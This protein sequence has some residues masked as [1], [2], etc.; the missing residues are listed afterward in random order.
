MVFG[1]PG[2]AACGYVE[3]A[4]AMN[5]SESYSL[6]FLQTGPPMIFTAPTL[7]A[8]VEAGVS[9]FDLER[10]QLA[11]SQSLVFLL[12]FGGEQTRKRF[13]LP[14]E[15]LLD[16]VYAEAMIRIQSYLHSW[17]LTTAM[18]EINE[19]LKTH[20]TYGT[21]NEI[22]S[23]YENVGLYDQAIEMR[24]KMRQL[25][26]QDDLLR[27]TDLLRLAS[28]HRVNA[29]EDKALA[30]LGEIETAMQGYVQARDSQAFGRTA[31]VRLAAAGQ[32]AACKQFG[33]AASLIQLDINA[34][35][36]Q[37]RRLTDPLMQVCIGIYSALRAEEEKG[38]NLSP[39]DATLRDNIAA[40][41]ERAFASGF[42]QE[43]DDFN[44][45]LGRYQLLG[46]FAVAREGKAASQERLLAAGPYPEKTREHW[47]RGAGITDEDWTWFRVCPP[48]YWAM[49]SALMDPEKPEIYQPE[50]ALALLKAMRQ[51]YQ[52]V[53]ERG[54]GSLAIMDGL[55]LSAAMRQAFLEKDL[56]AFE[57]LLGKIKAKNYSDYFGEAADEFGRSIHHVAARDFAA[58]FDRLQRSMPGKQYFFRAAYVAIRSKRYEQA[59]AIAESAAKAFPDDHAMAQEA[60]ALPKLIEKLRRRD[61]A[62]EQRKQAKT[63]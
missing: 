6:I 60:R 62:V 32:L 35:L 31:T 14:A 25:A 16:A 54:L 51:G 61:Q 38:V 12:R 15:V 5:G 30:C 20:P 55:M 13:G 47:K 41:L 19:L 22:F 59:L 34:A 58:W 23:I 49:A 43:S 9:A 40:L 53:A 10:G 21:Y 27:L 37:Q 11:N 63:P 50:Q 46:A 4:K 1:F 52:A 3:R 57:R 48:L 44:R 33:R 7:A 36:A 29:E 39:V 56:A 17:Y 18:R 28:I 26:P 45:V 42:F 8:A 2:H 24:E